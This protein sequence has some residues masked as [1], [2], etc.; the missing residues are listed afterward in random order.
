MGPHETLFQMGESSGPGIFIV[1]E[2]QLGV[3]LQEGDQLRHTNTLRIGESVGDYDVLDG[4]L[5]LTIA[6]ASLLHSTARVMFY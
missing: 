1:L 3:F 4:R 2:G 6:S 5:S